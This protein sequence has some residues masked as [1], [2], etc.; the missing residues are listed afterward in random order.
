MSWFRKAFDPSAWLAQQPGG[1][2]Y[3]VAQ[4]G[5][6]KNEPVEVFLNGHDL[7]PIHP[8]SVQTGP[9]AF[10]A[11]GLVRP[12]R[13]VLCLKVKNGIIR[14]P[15]FLTR[16]EPRRYPYLGT[17]QNARWVDL[18]DWTA[19]KLILGW[20]RGVRAAREDAPDVPLLF[21]PGSTLALADQ[22]LG[23]K[24]ELGIEAV[25][26]TGGGSNFMPWWPGI[27]Y[28]WGAYGTSEEGGTITDPRTLDNELAWM[29]LNGQGHHNYYYS[30]IDCMRVEKETGWFSRN[31]RPLE[32]IGKASWVRPAVALYRSARN[33][34]YFPESDSREV[35]DLGHGAFQAA[36]Y[37]N[38]YVTEAE[39]RA[40]LIRDYPVVFDAGNTVLDDA[41]L[42]A[43]A[44][45]VRGGGT[46]VA[47]ENTGR[48]SLLEPD[49][50]PIARLTGMRGA[51]HARE[52][53]ARDPRRVEALTPP[54]RRGLPGRRPGAGPD[55]SRPT[56]EVLP[57]IL[58][59]WS[60]GTAAAALGAWARGASW[61]SDRRSGA[62]AAIARAT[63]AAL[64]I[65][66]KPRCSPTS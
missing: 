3:M 27:G 50:W 40:G 43:L 21:C 55:G 20:K 33:D 66:C 46:L 6:R 32:L 49:A 36:H 18:R 13:N 61:C 42:N 57:E 38:V 60:D 2:V 44:D 65:A 15:V 52:H 22:F 58:A 16:H 34:L 12:G 63:A 5:D 39:I 24:R 41:T 10:R 54:G 56:S 59:R 9:V 31:R 23:L 37:A 11:T 30:A 48:H 62:A 28:V 53:A 17:Q 7:G 25:H 26:F 29:L 64:N 35:G 14:G 8:R 47:V 19:D 45:Y 51:G 1:A 4:V